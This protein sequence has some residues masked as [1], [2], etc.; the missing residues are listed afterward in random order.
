L[1]L[2]SSYAD[3]LFPDDELWAAG[4]CGQQAHRQDGGAPPRQ[5]CWFDATLVVGS[6]ACQVLAGGVVVAPRAVL[7]F[8]WWRCHGYSELLSLV[9]IVRQEWW[10]WA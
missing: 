4:V 8:S 1:T 5:R 2:M 6:R 3:N 9:E 10:F 7:G